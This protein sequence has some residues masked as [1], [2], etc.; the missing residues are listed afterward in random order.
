M[1][2]LHHKHKWRNIGSRI[3]N[4]ERGKIM[5]KKKGRGRPKVTEKIAGEQSALY[6][7]IIIGGQKYRSRRTI[8]DIAYAFEAM[9]ILS[10]VA[11]EIEDLELL[12]NNQTQY[13]CRSIL[14]QLG[15][16]YRT[17]GYRKES[18]VSVAKAAIQDKKNGY[19]VKEIER[20]IRNGRVTGEW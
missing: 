15:R 1:N 6:E 19:S 14:N 12:I 5:E 3:Q 16:M 10:E 20:Y 9:K 11:S 18:I 17:E 8:S 7:K 2:K 4:Y 13:M